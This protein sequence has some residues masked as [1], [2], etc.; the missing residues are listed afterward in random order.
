MDLPRSYR[1]APPAITVPAGTTVTWTN[2]DTFS[3]NVRFEGAEPQTMRPGE[4]TTRTF[5]E[6]G[7]FPYVCT[8]HAQDMTGSVLVTE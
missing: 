7:L 5:E 1:F 4:Q 2:S 6:P 3:H 8:F